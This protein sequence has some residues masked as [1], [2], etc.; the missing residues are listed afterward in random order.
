[1][2]QLKNELFPEAVVDCCLSKWKT[3]GSTSQKISYIS[4]NMLFLLQLASTSFSDGFHLE[5]KPLSKKTTVS[6]GQKI[7]FH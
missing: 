5:E 7:R 2:F 1:M 3:M 4:W 6:T